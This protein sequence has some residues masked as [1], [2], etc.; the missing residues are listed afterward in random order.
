MTQS[1]LRGFVGTNWWR[2]SRKHY[3]LYVCLWLLKVADYERNYS[4]IKRIVGKRSRCVG[5]WM[6][7]P[8]KRNVPSA[9][10]HHRRL[11][12]RYAERGNQTSTMMESLEARGAGASILIFSSTAFHDVTA[13]DFFI[14]VTSFISYNLSSAHKHP[15]GRRFMLDRP[16]CVS[17]LT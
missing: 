16:P 1:S 8:G 2:Q 9:H 3:S 15:M 4:W 14:H 10:P 7:P 12:D 6:M 11:I 17:L 13:V 5:G